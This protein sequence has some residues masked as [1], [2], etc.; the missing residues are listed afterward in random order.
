[1]TVATNHDPSPVSHTPRARPGIWAGLFAMNL[2]IIA[3][4][5]IT[6]A[7]EGATPWILFALNFLLLIPMIRS[8]KALQEQ[9]GAMSPA[10]R[11]YNRRFLIFAFLYMAVMLGSSALHDHVAPS[12][13]AIW[14]LAVA[15]LL[16]IF[17][18][19]ATMARY[20]REETDEFLRHRA[21]NAAL[22]GLALVLIVGT[23]WGFLEMFGLVPHV[24]TWAVFP[25]WA[26]GLGIGT[27][28]NRLPA[29]EE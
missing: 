25:L 3:V 29:G 18:M 27:L 6:G 11:S 21:V 24:W 14:L 20:L 15:P 23:S 10:L 1:M 22:I 17:G 9:K 12:S 28:F 7:L 4:L 13:P 19:I 5:M 2:A 26:I 16:P 8:A